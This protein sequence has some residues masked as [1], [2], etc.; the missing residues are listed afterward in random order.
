MARRGKVEADHSQPGVWAGAGHASVLTSDSARVAERS[1]EKIRV[2]VDVAAVASERFERY[3]G[4]SGMDA[5][6]RADV[7]GEKKAA[8]PD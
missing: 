7:R 2:P 3:R 5:S 8:S 4:A 1:A 6:Y